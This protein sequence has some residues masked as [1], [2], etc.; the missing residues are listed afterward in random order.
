MS[1]TKQINSHY[2]SH[3]S[4]SNKITLLTI[5]A[6]TIIQL[7]LFKLLYPFANYMPSSYSYLETADMNL[8]INIWPSGYSKFLRFFS[9]FTHS[10]LALTTFQYF[11]LTACSLYF[12]FTVGKNFQLSRLSKTVMLTLLVINPLFLYVSNYI[13]PDAIFA[14]LSLLWFTQ[15][16]LLLKK[17]S[18]SLI[19][20]HVFVLF[21]VFSFGYHALYFPIITIIVFISIELKKRAKISAIILVV[22]SIGLYILHIRQQYKRLTGNNHFAPVCGWLLASN[23]LVMNKN[24]PS[25]YK[26]QVPKRFSLLHQLV[27]KHEDSLQKIHVVPNT[28]KSS[29]YLNDSSSPLNRYWYTQIKTDT[30]KAVSKSWAQ[31][32]S[33]YYE[34]GLMLIRKH[35]YSYFNSIILPGITDFITPPTELLSVYNMDTDTV[36]KLAQ[37][38]F[39]YKTNQV[40]HIQSDS[41]LAILNLYPL[42]STIIQFCFLTGLLSFVLLKGLQKTN[43][44]VSFIFWLYMIWWLAELLM[45]VSIST[46]T[47]RHQIFPMVVCLPA[48][49]FFIEFSIKAERSVSHTSKN[50]SLSNF[51]SVMLSGKLTDEGKLKTSRKE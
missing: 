2:L 36:P 30:L 18:L 8:D 27:K 4:W 45:G 16:L 19:L 24:L 49:L 33:L 50:T 21:I 25:N 41:V 39:S 43:K 32:G 11:F 13:S 40:M 28:I 5:A 46:T 22:L 7:F 1:A 37:K 9:A 47:L 14:A 31:V 44:Y 51:Y 34:Y 20:S 26:E 17:P 23:A 38:W 10:D 29:Y 15:L 42:I 12:A 6:I 48:A 3:I 35:P